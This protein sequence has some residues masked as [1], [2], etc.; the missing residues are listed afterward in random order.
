MEMH[1]MHVLLAPAFEVSCVYWSQ[2]A[3]RMG[4]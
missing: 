3:E 2:S 4:E 1:A